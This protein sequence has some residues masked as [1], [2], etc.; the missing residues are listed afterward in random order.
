MQPVRTAGGDGARE[1]RV[2]VPPSGAPPSTMLTPGTQ[3][4]GRPGKP[5]VPSDPLGRWRAHPPCPG[6]TVLGEIRSDE[7]G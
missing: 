2:R 6:A 1:Q 5:V 3:G 7:K 4:E